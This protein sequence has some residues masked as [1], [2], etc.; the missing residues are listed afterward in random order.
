MTFKER[1][2][3]FKGSAINRTLIEPVIFNTKWILVPFYLGLI[4]A[5]LTFSLTYIQQTFLMIVECYF[6]HEKMS[7]SLVEL[8]LL[9]LVDMAMIANLVRTVITGSYN[10]FVNKDHGYKGEN[11]SGGTLKI[12]LHTSLV[13]ISSMHLLHS[14]LTANQISWDELNKQIAIH[15]CFIA[16]AAFLVYIKRQH[17]EMEIREIALAQAEHEHEKHTVEKEVSH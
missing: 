14:F 3:K 8:A 17:V 10:S 11:V 6:G 12:S 7:V 1:W 4:I 16:G 13:S 9:E 5:M 15:L 2:E